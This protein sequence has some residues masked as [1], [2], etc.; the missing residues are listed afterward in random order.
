[1]KR[2]FFTMFFFII[3]LLPVFSQSEFL[4]AYYVTYSNDTINGYIDFRGHFRAFTDFKFKKVLHAEPIILN[5][6]DAQ[7]VRFVN[8]GFYVP[9]DIPED[10]TGKVF[11]EQLI[12]GI[13]DVYCYRQ[14][15]EMYYLIRDDSGKVY[16]LKNTT[17]K[18]IKDGRNYERDVKEYLGVLSLL[19]QDSPTTIKKLQ[20]VSLSSNSLIDISEFYHNDVCD[21]YSCM[22]YSKT[23]LK[24]N[25]DFGFTAGYAITTISLY[26]NK[27][28][29]N[30][31]ADFDFSK[32]PTF[33]LF[34]NI[35]EPSLSQRF[36][37][38]FES[39][40]QKNE[41][42]TDTSA[43]HFS[44]LKIPVIVK[45]S[46]P[47]KPI[48]PSFQIGAS[49]NS[50]HSFSD[51]GIV[52]DIQNRLAIQS[53]RFQYGALMGIELSTSLDKVNFFLQ[54][55]YELLRGTHH[56]TWTLYGGFVPTNTGDIVKSK[57]NILS[58]TGGI[59]F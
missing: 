59:K 11:I 4:E 35:S 9:M 23:K 27:W 2:I 47:L 43:I 15:H 22:I 7:C 57:N 34:L 40:Y 21:D 32:S 16:R 46:L 18:V 20:N 45:Y 13:V 19:F 53:K 56:N 12:D 24:F 5:I 38:Q 54:A 28:A 31:N 30:L 26:K 49:Y 3:C 36:S 37:I 6:N 8:E 44:Y 50:W 29:E 48:L 55:R 52:P 14:N 25:F 1:M 10:S 51:T 33:G 41:F 39:N 42:A 58:I 17:Q